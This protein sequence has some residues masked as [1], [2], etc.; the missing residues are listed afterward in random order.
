[1]PTLACEPAKTPAMMSFE[2]WINDRVSIVS[3]N[4][5][6]PH[7][8]RLEDSEYYKHVTSSAPLERSLWRV[9]EEIR[10]RGGSVSP[11]R[12][13]R[14]GLQLFQGKDISPQ[15]IVRSF[16][17]GVTLFFRNDDR[18]VE[19]EFLE[20]DSVAVVMYSPGHPIGVLEV[21]RSAELGEVALRTIA[22]FLGA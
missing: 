7:N 22:G 11:V 5:N 19:V 4:V 3:G 1:M 20:D 14:R 21:P 12:A 10:G 9:R 15:K 13:A 17:N 8:L 2:K 16:E 18:R 6:S